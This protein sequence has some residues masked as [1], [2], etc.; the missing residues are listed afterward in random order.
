ML[1]TITANADI[2][3]LARLMFVARLWRIGYWALILSGA[4]AVAFVIEHYTGRSSTPWIARQVVTVLIAS[5]VASALHLSITNVRFCMAARMQRLIANDLAH[6][7]PLKKSGKWRQYIRHYIEVLAKTHSHPTALNGYAWTLATCP[8]AECRSGDK[9]LDA[10]LCACSKDGFRSEAFL[11]TLAAAYAELGRFESALYCQ[12]LA[13][14]RCSGDRKAQLAPRASLYV[15]GVPFRLGLDIQA[16]L[17]QLPQS[18]PAALSNN[19]RTA[20]WRWDIM[21][22]A[23]CVGNVWTCLVDVAA[24][25][26]IPAVCLAPIA[27]L[28]AV[29]ITYPVLSATI[30][31]WLVVVAIIGAIVVAYCAWEQVRMVVWGLVIMYVLVWSGDKSGSSR[32]PDNYDLKLMGRQ[33]LESVLREPDSLEIIEEKLILPVRYG[34]SVVYYAR[35]RARNGFGGM[36]IDEY[37]TEVK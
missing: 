30:A 32:T 31:A 3:H 26:A 18:A 5:I 29:V 28:V 25:V 16:M 14:A 22:I 10:A 19:N 35:Y 6:L 15:A 27:M 36:S 7:L 33:T 1:P 17:A 9:A 4:Y 12:M 2:T 13:L 20:W 8:D 24:A 11:D 37:Y 23:E 21:F 34:A